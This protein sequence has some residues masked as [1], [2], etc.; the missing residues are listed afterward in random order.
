MKCISSFEN[1]KS[2]KILKFTDNNILANGINGKNIGFILLIQEL[3][4]DEYLGEGYAEDL[5]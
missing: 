3:S 4:E 5:K 1:K 2:K